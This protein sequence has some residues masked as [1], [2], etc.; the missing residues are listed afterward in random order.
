M[1]DE[2][3]AKLCGRPLSLANALRKLHNY[4]RQVPMQANPTT[5]HLFI[6]NPLTG[7]GFTNLFST[8][9]PIERRIARLEELAIS[10]R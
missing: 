1:A 4:S 5:A 2:S 9:P 10:P 8:H 7:G 3:G 6:V